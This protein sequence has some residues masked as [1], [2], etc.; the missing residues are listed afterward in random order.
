M[1]KLKSIKTDN[2]YL[3][4]ESDLRCQH[5]SSLREIA[6]GEQLANVI[7]SRHMLPQLLKYSAKKHIT[8]DCRRRLVTKFNVITV[9]IT[10]S[11][12][13]TANK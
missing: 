8:D 10:K 12:M 1:R 4:V 11:G 6:L 2:K 13:I 9:G 3:L 7:F 5:E